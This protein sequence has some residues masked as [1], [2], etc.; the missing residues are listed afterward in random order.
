MKLLTTI[1][2]VLT[3]FSAFAGGGASSRG[4]V[5]FSL[6]IV[7]LLTILLALVYLFEFMNRIRKDKDYRVQLKLRVLNLISTVRAIF[8]KRTEEE[9]DNRIDYSVV[10]ELN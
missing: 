7:A 3:S 6:S 8:V 9:Q 10:L 1:L 4:D 5:L 2:I